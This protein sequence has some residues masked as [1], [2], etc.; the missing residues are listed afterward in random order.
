MTGVAWPVTS[1]AE[2]CAIKPAKSE[3]RAKLADSDDVSFAPMEDL[4]IGSKYLAQSRTRRLDEVSRSY[5]YFADGDVLL[6]KITPCFENGKLGVARGLVNGVGFGSSEYIVLRPSPMLDSEFLYYFLARPTFREEGARTMTGAVGHKRVAKEFVENYQIPLPPLPEQRRIV[7]ILDEAFEGIATAKANAEKNLQ[8]ASELI[9][10]GYQAITEGLDRSK[11]L[12]SPVTA[13]AAPRKGSMRTGPFG[14]QLLHSEF[15]DD[16]I[17]VL[18]IDNAVAN[19]FRWDRRRY[20][21]EEKYRDLARHR[22]FPGDV[23]ITIMGTCGRC[24]VVPD[25]IPLAINTKHLCCIT[26][27][28]SR[29]LPEYLHLYFL[30]DPTAREYLTAQAKGSIMAGQNMGF[31][32]ELPVRLPAIEQQNAIIDRFNLLRGE[33][34]RL[35]DVQARKLAALDELKK[36]LLHQAFSGAL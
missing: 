34:D 15:V 23:L 3:A 10:T 13:L 31:I 20:I 21:S 32:S 18:G 33:C 36:S 19:E 9:G 35:L 4:G 7:A 30:H 16:G 5:T 8:R 14:S 22:V 1:L 24:A 6:A 28:R 2:V 26:L 27:D 17:A 25:D 12:I 11:W 29:C